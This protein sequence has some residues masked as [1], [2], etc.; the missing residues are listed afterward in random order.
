MNNEII[1]RVCMG[2]GGIASGGK[3]VLDSFSAA[4]SQHKVSAVLKEKCSAHKVGCL[5]LC[6]RD[7]LVEIQKN[8]SKT[9]YQY[10][11]PKMVERIVG[12]RIDRNVPEQLGGN[13]S[14]TCF[15]V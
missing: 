13:V 4:L 1:I 8:G 2:P 10:V 3:N 9:V 15:L 5:G 6:A 14:V 11:K 12:I 7:V